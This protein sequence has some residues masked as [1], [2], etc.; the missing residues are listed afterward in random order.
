MA[1]TFDI[2]HPPTTLIHMS[3]DV[4]MV[5]RGHY[6][7]DHPPHNMYSHQPSRLANPQAPAAIS[8]CGAVL[9]QR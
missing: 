7:P 5:N 6:R 2:A 9:V 1:L 8:A 3:N 4:Q